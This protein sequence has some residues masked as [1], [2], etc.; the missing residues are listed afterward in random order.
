[1]VS[2]PNRRR[3]IV[4]LVILLQLC[5][6]TVAAVAYWAVRPS[7]RCKN[8]AQGPAQVGWSARTLVSGGRERCYSLYVPPGYDPS[9]PV[10]LVVSLHGF[11]MNPESQA[12]V[13]RWHELA[14]RVG[15]L[16]AYPQGT[17]FPQRWGSYGSWGVGGVDDVQFLHDVLD[18]LAA[19][20]AVD[21]SRVYVNGLSN[22]GGMSVRIGCE[23]AAQV[24]AIGSVAG[25]V[26]NLQDCN[27]SRPVPAIV[28]QGTADP[29]V[30][31]EGGRLS[32]FG[33]RWG[34]EL[35]CIPRVFLGV[36]DWVAIWAEGNGCDPL[37][38]AI[39]LQGDVRGVRYTGCEQ[40]AEVILY[41]IESGGHQWPGGTPIPGLGKTSTDI[42]AA[43]E[44]W[45]FFQMHRLEDQP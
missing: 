25:A 15:F 5:V 41:T 38:E 2:S 31:Y 12:V 29:L 27:P 37:P 42:S 18:D 9:Q 7:Q 16:V 21:R 3:L 43:E 32:W 34:A 45:R 8:P 1:M 24:A 33:L 36:E 20:A 19:V 26:V 17:S 11:A 30:N 4:A 40:D 22:G 44:M 13:S 39:P 6:L 10:P 28:F 35:T 14:D 23:A